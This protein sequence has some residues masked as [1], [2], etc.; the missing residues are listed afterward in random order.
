M[1]ERFFRQA[2][3][4]RFISENKYEATTSWIPEEIAKVGNLIRIKES[5]DAEWEENWKVVKVY[6]RKSLSQLSDKERDYLKQ[7]Q[8]S[9]V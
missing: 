6:D 3:L 8:A 2:E 1:A 9:D 7:R 4:Y 5:S